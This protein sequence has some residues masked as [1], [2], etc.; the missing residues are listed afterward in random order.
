MISMLIDCHGQTARASRI[1]R[2]DGRRDPRVPV[3]SPSEI[4]MLPRNA[5]VLAVLETVYVTEKQAVATY[6]PGLTCTACPCVYDRKKQK[7]GL[8]SGAVESLNRR[9]GVLQLLCM[10]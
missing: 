6:F 9:L 3:L 1:L 7:P 4:E 5:L 2:R 8:K 10:K